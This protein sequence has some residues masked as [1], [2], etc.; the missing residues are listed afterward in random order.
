MAGSLNR[1]QLIGN[2]G[3]DP[4]IRSL[5]NGSKV[6]D[7]SIATSESWT[8]KQTGERK[9]QTEWHRVVIWIEPIVKVV[10]QYLRKGSK[11]MIEGKLSTRKW[12]DQSGADRYTTEIVLS[13]YN[14]QLIMLGD[15]GGGEGRRGP[16]PADSP[17]GPMQRPQGAAGDQRGYP[18]NTLGD[19]GGGGAPAGG[20]RS[21]MD[22]EIPFSPEWR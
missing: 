16:P 8:D 2:L 13:G 6:A 17:P 10:E 20:R 9:E 7:L 12:Q 21:D 11:V 14:G 22:D 19:Q 3:R 18:Y 1:V 15:A 4:E 5:Q